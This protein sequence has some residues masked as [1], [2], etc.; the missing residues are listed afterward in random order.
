MTTYKRAR[1][2][3]FNA[4]DAFKNEVLSC[5]TG[6]SDI[7]ETVTGWA[8]NNL[9]LFRMEWADITPLVKDTY[10]PYYANGWMSA[11]GYLV[12]TEVL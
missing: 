4:L 3:L 11:K 6:E 10:L 1:R 2:E 7:V 9:E 5:K 12:A 8:D